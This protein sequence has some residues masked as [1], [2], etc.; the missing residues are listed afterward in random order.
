[1]L[2]YLPL[3][4][5]YGYHWDGRRIERKAGRNGG[6]EERREG[7]RKRGRKRMV[8]KRGREGKAESI[9]KRC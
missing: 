9:I 7:G 8:K 3:L 6:I 2:E 1:L 4:R 5:D